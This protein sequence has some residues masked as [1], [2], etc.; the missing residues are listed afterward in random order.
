MGRELKD[1]TIKI[2]TFINKNNPNIHLFMRVRGGGEIHSINLCI[3]SD[4]DGRSDETGC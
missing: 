2:S 4:C 3:K 1:P